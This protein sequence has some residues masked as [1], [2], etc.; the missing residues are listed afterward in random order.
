M[1]SEKIKKALKLPF[2]ILAIG[3][4]LCLFVLFVMTKTSNKPVFIAN[5]TTMWVMTESMSPTIAPKTY[6]LVEKVDA[7]EVEVGDIVVFV[8][9]DPRIYGQYNTHRVIEKN[10]DNFVT[11][12]DNNPGDDGIYSAQAENIVARYVRTLTVMT[13]LGRL[14][15]SP[16]GFAVVMALFVLTTILCI[17]PDI[18]NALKQK[19]KEDDEEKKREMER[20]IQEEVAKMERQG[21]TCEE[22]RKEIE[23]KENNK[24]A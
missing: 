18:R 9:T 3:I 10:G 2:E 17:L 8:S 23:D 21:V 11:K 13:F 24:K 15:L 1:K 7:S 20:L 5:K 16:V 12:G 4:L 19:D 22:L 6:V 14:V